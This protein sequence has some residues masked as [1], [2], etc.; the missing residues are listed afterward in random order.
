[1]NSVVVFG[2]AVQIAIDQIL[3][4]IKIKKDMGTLNKNT[5]EKIEIIK[6]AEFKNMFQYTN[7]N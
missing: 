6:K 2:M 4:T 1:M 7:A 5:N 3:L